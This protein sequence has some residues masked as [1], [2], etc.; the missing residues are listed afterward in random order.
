MLR[1]SAPTGSARR[2]RGRSRRRRRPACVHPWRASRGDP[3]RGSAREAST[4]A[5]PPGARSPATK[6]IW[7]M[8]K[9]NVAP[10]SRASRPTIS[11]RRDSRM[12]AALRKMPWRCAGTLCDHSGKARAAAATACTASS[13]EPAGTSATTSPVKGSWTSNVPP[14]EAS[15]HSPPMNCLASRTSGPTLVTLSPFVCPARQRA[16]RRSAPVSGSV[17]PGLPAGQDAVP[18][19]GTSPP[20]DEGHA[21][22]AAANDANNASHPGVARTDVHEA[23]GAC[24]RTG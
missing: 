16:L 10:V 4:P 6:P 7:N 18:V 19:N 22:R 21:I 24:P 2:S 9:P 23:T 14:P 20:G 3:R 11:S 13:R 5:P 1:S 8:P 17:R 12:S 15:V